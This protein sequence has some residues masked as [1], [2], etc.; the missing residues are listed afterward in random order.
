MDPRPREHDEDA[1]PVAGD[2]TALLAAAVASPA[3]A[4]ALLETLVRGCGLGIALIDGARRYA[5]ANEALAA[6]DGIAAEDHVD[7]PVVEVLPG[8]VG[9]AMEALALRV[10]RTGAVARDEVRWSRDGDGERSRLVTLHPIAAPGGETVGA[11][12]VVEEL[13]ERE[14]AARRMIDEGASFTTLADAL[15]AMVWMG[16]DRGR[17]TFVN[18]RWLELAGGDLERRARGRLAAAGAPG[19]PAGAGG[20]A[21]RGRRGGGRARARVP[22]AP[23]RRR[24]PPDRRPRRPPGRR[25]PAASW[26]TS[27]PAPT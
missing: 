13:S 3:T 4:G 14:R 7:R 25:E 15:P 21:A 2:G 18:R 8:P 22:P 16:D 24:V 12:A 27:G 11:I 6:L 26:A 1:A 9:D 10:L 19:R 17:R 23:G 20:G 5:W